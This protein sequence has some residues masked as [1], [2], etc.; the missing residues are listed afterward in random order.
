MKRGLTFCISFILVLAGALTGRV[1]R[2]YTDY[3][4]NPWK[5][6]PPFETWQEELKLD[7]II[8]GSVIIVCIIVAIVL[9]VLIKKRGRQELKEQEDA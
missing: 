5:Y 9:R 2:V 7:F 6:T 4:A 1:I 8:N 3:K